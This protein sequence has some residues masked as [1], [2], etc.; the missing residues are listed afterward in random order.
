[1]VKTLID[2]MSD[3]D[4]ARYNEL[5]EMAAKAKAEAPKAPR[6]SKGPMTFEQKKK[7]AE[8]RLAKAKEK[9]D[10]L[11]AAQIG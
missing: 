10:A 6:A 5:L 9:L 1:M 8:A 11:L 2:Y 4:Y 7:M 3:N